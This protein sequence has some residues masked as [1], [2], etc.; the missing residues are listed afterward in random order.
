MS[1]FFALLLWFCGGGLLSGLAQSMI[2]KVVPRNTRRQIPCLKFG[3]FFSLA[4]LSLICLLVT[5]L[6]DLTASSSLFKFI[7]FADV[8]CSALHAAYAVRRY[9]TYARRSGFRLGSNLGSL[10]F[11]ILYVC[12]A[13]F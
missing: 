2:L 5:S 1:T 10:L 8:L 13:L 12:Y 6:F 11:G 3:L 4:R 7:I 9:G